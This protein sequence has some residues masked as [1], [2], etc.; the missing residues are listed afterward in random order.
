LLKITRF[1][2]PDTIK[3]RSDPN[4][5]LSIRNNIPSEKFLHS[6]MRYYVWHDIFAAAN[7]TLVKAGLFADPYS[8]IYGA[9]GIIPV[10][11]MSSLYKD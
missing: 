11:F 10:V 1:E 6:F 3:E 2:F 4:I 7:R 9:K 5:V 8:Q